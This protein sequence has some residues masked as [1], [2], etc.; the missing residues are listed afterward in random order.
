MDWNARQLEFIRAPLENGRLLGVPGGGKTRC[1]LG[2]VL[3]LIDQ[4]DVPGA[5]GFLVLAFSNLAVRD[6]LNKG[7]AMR[8]GVFTKSNVR[9]IHSLSGA[10]V[11]A[12]LGRTSSSINTVVYRAGVEIGKMSADE[13]RETVRCLR[14]VR[15]VFVDEAQDMSEV[16]YSLVESLS[17]V[18]RAPLC[19]VG[20]PNQSIYAFQNGSDRFLRE[21]GGFSVSLTRNYRSTPELV[22][23]VDACKPV[24]G[25]AIEA[26]TPPGNTR[27]ELFCD[28]LEAIADDVVAKCR[29][30]LAAGETVAVVGPVRKSLVRWDGTCAN[31][32][33]TYVAAALDKSGIPFLVHYKEDADARGE[34]DCDAGDA[35]RVHLLTA[36]KAKGLEFDSVLAVNFHHATMGREPGANDV[37]ALACLWY[38]AMSRARRRMTVYCDKGRPVWPGY[39][40]L[41]PLLDVSRREPSLP[42]R[43]PSERPDPV[44]FAWT[45]LLNDRVRLPEEDLAVLEDAFAFRAE[46]IGRDPLAPRNPLPEENALSA[47]YGIWAEET[48]AH[49]YRLHPP[50]VLGWIRAMLG[51]V[52]VPR[53]LLRALRELRAATGTAR[54]EPLRRSCVERHRQAFAGSPATAAIVDFLDRHRQPD[55]RDEI[56]VHSDTDMVFWDAGVAS[57]LAD[58]AEREGRI[59]VATMWRMC[60]LKWQY[61]NE[62]GYR[63]AMDDGPV[64]AGL[65]PYG[66]LVA[67][68]AAEQPDGLEFQVG[69]CMPLSPVRG[70]ADAVSH[71][72]RKI[73]ELKFSVADKEAAHALQALGYAEML[74]GRTPEAWTVEVHNLRTGSAHRVVRGDRYDRWAVA[75]MLS[76]ATGAKISGAVWL[77]DLET[78]GLCTASCRLLEAHLEE[79]NSGIVALS[80]LVRQDH[81]PAEVTRI[82]GISPGMLDGAPD[83]DAVASEFR[84]ALEACRAPVLAAHNGARFDHEI[85]KRLRAIPEGTLLRDTMHVLPVALLG[86]KA[87]GERRALGKMFEAEIGETVEA[88]RAKADVYMMARLLDKAGFRGRV[89]LL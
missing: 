74:G 71:A 65:L 21:F 9:T 14:H 45:D 40:R 6:F 76:R 38:V 81:V 11:S 23:V 27:P 50:P 84:A 35:S 31:V 67:R 44:Q 37:G 89:D 4:G 55:S 28:D 58:A 80:T 13:I 75:R 8:A 15:A 63:W 36:H 34:S 46:D 82:T 39:A 60:L 68:M 1:L 70:V 69:A 66:E 32:G 51:A 18:L 26:E 22:A 10:I 83:Q 62:C 33:L 53:H 7:R 12:A 19:L 72:N 57:A 87:K 41:A 77:Y 30:C 54:S 3:R 49:A 20:D 29:A 24:P 73:I 56:Y 48:Y 61:E 47:L 79:Y 52:V 78:T 59:S 16:Q 25:D 43:P 86:A 64:V 2:R 88:H 85:M 5:D 42:K 17:E